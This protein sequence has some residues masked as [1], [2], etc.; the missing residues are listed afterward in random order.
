MF[1]EQLYSSTKKSIIY[2]FRSAIM[3]NDPVRHPKCQLCNRQ[4]IAKRN[5]TKSCRHHKG[6]S[7]IYISYLAIP[8]ICIYR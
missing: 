1:T 2:I 6:V 7:K 8:L 5:Y 4:F 3:F